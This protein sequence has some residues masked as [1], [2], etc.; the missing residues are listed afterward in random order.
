MLVLSSSLWYSL[1]LPLDITSFGRLYNRFLIH[2]TVHFPAMDEN[3]TELSRNQV[4]HLY[5]HSLHVYC[6]WHWP[7]KAF[8]SPKSSSRVHLYE[9]SLLLTRCLYRYVWNQTNRLY[10]W[11]T[12]NY[13]LTYHLHWY[14]L[15]FYVLS[16]YLCYILLVPR[17]QHLLLVA[18]R[19]M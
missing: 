18:H 14:H 17:V 15:Y 5:K 10:P 11:T 7:Y 2:H 13:V 8:V 9:Y 16:R 12:V 1:Y 19:T 6:M 4:S 3:I